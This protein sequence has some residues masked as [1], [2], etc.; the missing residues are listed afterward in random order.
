MREVVT[1]KSIPAPALELFSL[2]LG[3]DA[4]HL[5]PRRERIVE[6]LLPK[7]REVLIGLLCCCLIR[8]VRA[9]G[10]FLLHLTHEFPLLAS[11]VVLDLPE[12]AA[13]L[14]TQVERGSGA[15]ASTIAPHHAGPHTVTGAVAIHHPGAHAVATIATHHA[16]TH[17]IAGTV[18]AHHSGPH[19]PAWSV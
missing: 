3:E 1:L 14:V 18:S 7:L 2:L 9:A 19:A 17:A 4:V 8:G 15:P 13:L 11:Q 16:R 10:V 6:H 12:F 5:L